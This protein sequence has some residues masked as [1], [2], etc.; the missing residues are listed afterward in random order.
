[1]LTHDNVLFVDDEPRVLKA[2]ERVFIDEPVNLLFAACADE[3]LEL[4][5]RN[6]VGVVVSDNIMEGMLGVDFLRCVKFAS[7]DCTRVL[8]TGQADLE[9]AIDAINNG[10]IYKFVTKPWDSQQLIH[11]VKESLSQFAARKKAR[12]SA[13]R[14]LSQTIELKDPYT[15]GHCERVAFYA[16]LIAG[17]I[18]L[19][20]TEKKDIRDGSWLHDCGKIGVPERILNNGG[21]LNP[22]EFEL[23]KNH[24]FWGADLARRAQ[25]REGVINI[26]L[27]HHEKFDG[28]GYPRGIAG[29]NIP[30]ESR[31]VAI[32]D[33]YDAMTTD[34]PYQDKLPHEFALNNIMQ[35]RGTCFDPELVDAFMTA[36]E[37]CHGI[38]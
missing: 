24:T 36:L 16:V 17:A 29:V 32:A 8:M 6:S 27:Y 9:T 33:A 23:V 35:E 22:E 18:G 5:Q 11:M 4:I 31:I 3:A 12:D 28:R 34:R 10:E 30:L 20:D 26:I 14:A 21:E 37:G 25:L 7:P 2:I 19:N 38:G 1:M 13:L 15:N